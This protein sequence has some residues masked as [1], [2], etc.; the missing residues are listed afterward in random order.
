MPSAIITTEKH[1]VGNVAKED[2][3][4]WNAAD[5]LHYFVHTVEPR[6]EPHTDAHATRHRETGTESEDE[7]PADR[8]IK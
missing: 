5:H 3:T 2:I 7:A 4:D 8:K 6:V 1:A